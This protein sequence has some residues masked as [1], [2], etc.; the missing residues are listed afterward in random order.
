MA[1]SLIAAYRKLGGGAVAVR[2]SA[3]TEDLADASFAGQQD[4]FLNVS[5]DD[6]L[7]RAVSACWAS[8]W[9]ERAAAYRN[10]QAILDEPALAIIVQRMVDARCA[11]VSFTANPVTGCRDEVVTDAAPG[12]GEAIVSGS[13]EPDHY[14]VGSTGPSGRPA[15]GGCLTAAQL[16]VV[17]DT[18][19]AVQASF[20]APQ[21][22]EWAIDHD[23]ALWITQSRPITTLYPLPRSVHPQAPP[24]NGRRVFL[25]ASHS[26]QGIQGPITRSGLSALAVATASVHGL[27]GRPNPDPAKG[28]GY[29]AIAGSRWFLDL[30]GALLDPRG[31]ELV[32]AAVGLVDVRARAVLD[33]LDPTQ[34][35][36]PRKGTRRLFAYL[37]RIAFR[38]GVLARVLDA[39]VRPARARRRI[40]LLRSLIESDAAAARSEG[41]RGAQ[42]LIEDWVGRLWVRIVPITGVGMFLAGIGARMSGAHAD[43]PDVLAAVRAVPDNVTTAMDLELWQVLM[44]DP[45]GVEVAAASGAG[46]LAR[47][48]AQGELPRRMQAALQEFLSRHGHR[49]VAEIDL[50]VPRWSQD[51]TPVMASLISMAALSADGQDPCVDQVRKASEAREA[52]ERLADGAGLRRGLV[53]WAYGGA[54]ILLGLR[55]Q[56]KYLNVLVLARAREILEESARRLVA[57]GLIAQVDDIYHLDFDEIRDAEGGRPMHGVVRQRRDEYVRESRRKRVPAILLSDGTDPETLIPADTADRGSLCGTPASPGLAVGRA[58]IVTEPSGARIEPGDVLVAPTTDPAWTPLFLGAAAVVVQTGGVNSH[59]AV[60]AREFGIPA[61]VGVVGVLE[62]I[63]SGTLVEIDG[64]RG[65]V[66]LLQTAEP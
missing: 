34:L 51:A 21:D 24:D 61:V 17:T 6:D 62:R 3:T 7:I 60:V 23:G 22:I 57:A 14:V 33:S 4:T 5:G 8:L 37:L 41:V 9:N 13:V 66:K 40:E 16:E 42:R 2:S 29:V 44:A 10:R 32:T 56:A 65:T 19:R 58:R 45:S 64:S 54:R 1:A 18:A 20:G 63:E 43:H 47:Q 26:W 15:I 46:D 11:G 35:G 28:T 36:T 27:S 50:G 31:R 49:S 52:I 30:T 39:A 59:G 53:L 48:F 25:C 12:L 38:H 55:E